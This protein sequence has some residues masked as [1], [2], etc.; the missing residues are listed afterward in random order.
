MRKLFLIIGLLLLVQLLWVATAAAAPPES[1]GFWHRVR[2]GES[3]S[4]IGYRYGVNPSAICAANG[5]YNC[6]RIYAGQRLWIPAQRY[7]YDHRHYRPDY[8][9]DYGQVHVVRPG[10]TLSG[11]SRAYGVNLWA[12]ARANNLYNIHHIYAGQRLY[13]PYW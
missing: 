7:D 12:I 3:L 8:H 13:I 6:N 11:I 10:Q 5:L 2:Y 9:R 4:T 1:G